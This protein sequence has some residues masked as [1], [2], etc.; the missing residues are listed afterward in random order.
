MNEDYK[1][2]HLSVQGIDKEMFSNSF[3]DNK[4][5]KINFNGVIKEQKISIPSDV[6]STIKF[7]Y[8]E[9]INEEN[10]TIC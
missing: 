8:N 2:Y 5:E 10:N 3:Y 6:L 4:C 7:Y 9:S 1:I